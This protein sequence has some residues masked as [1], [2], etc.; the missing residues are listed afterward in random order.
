MIPVGWSDRIIKFGLLTRHAETS[1]SWTKEFLLDFF[2]KNIF[3]HIKKLSANYM[4]VC[5]YDQ[6]CLQM[7]HPAGIL[8]SRMPEFL[9]ACSLN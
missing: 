2:F 5:K 8:D 9:W 6:N 1:K 3:G 7:S 4:I